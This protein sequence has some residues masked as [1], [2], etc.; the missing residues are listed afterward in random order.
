MVSH[1]LGLLKEFCDVALFIGRD[2]KVT[3]FDSVSE[4]ILNYKKDEQRN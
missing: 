2:N 1:S 4:A 3:Y